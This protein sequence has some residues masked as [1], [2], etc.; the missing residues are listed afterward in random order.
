MHGAGEQIALQV[1]RPD[2]FSFNT[3]APSGP[4]IVRHR[5]L[6][7]RGWAVTH[8]PGS[9]WAKLDDAVRGAWLLQ[10]RYHIASC[11]NLFALFAAGACALTPDAE[12]P[13]CNVLRLSIRDGW[14]AA[15]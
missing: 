6:M 5:L 2:K 11:E 3:S 14:V 4:T 9:M 1:D 13:P 7:A 8:V 12:L 10:A 15:A